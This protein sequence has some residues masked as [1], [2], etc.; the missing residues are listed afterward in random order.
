MRAEISRKKMKANG[1]CCEEKLFILSFIF[2]SLGRQ[3]KNFVQK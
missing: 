3:E 2:I 1:K